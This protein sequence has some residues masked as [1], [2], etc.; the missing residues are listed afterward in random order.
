VRSGSN[1]TAGSAGWSAWTTVVSGADMPGTNRYL[2]YRATL[3]TNS[4][5]NTAPTLS[6]V[7]LAYAVP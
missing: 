4:T 7:Q 3:T 2:Q 1:A 6:S 5:R